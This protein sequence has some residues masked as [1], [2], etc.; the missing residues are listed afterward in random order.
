MISEP[1]KVMIPFFLAWKR[2][3][4]KDLAIASIATHLLFLSNFE[5]SCRVTRT[6]GVDLTRLQTGYFKCLYP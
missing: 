4:Q 1:N 2:V 6:R 3:R 5:E